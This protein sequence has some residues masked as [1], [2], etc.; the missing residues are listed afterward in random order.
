MLI[1]YALAKYN[2]FKVNFWRIL[3]H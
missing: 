1:Y 2:N 3:N